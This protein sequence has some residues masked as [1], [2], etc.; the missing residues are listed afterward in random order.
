VTFQF[1]G[2]HSSLIVLRADL[3][4]GNDR[5][6][7]STFDIAHYEQ[8]SVV[9]VEFQMD[10]GDDTVVYEPTADLFGGSVYRM[11]IVTGAGS[12][13]VSGGVSSFV[14]DGDLTIDVDLGTG[15]DLLVWRPPPGVLPDGAVRISVAG[16]PGHDVVAFNHPTPATSSLAGLVELFVHGDDGNDEIVVNMSPPVSGSTVTGTVRVHADGGAGNDSVE[17]S[18]QNN[19][20]STGTLDFLVRGGLG[21][22]RLEL[23]V[24]GPAIYTPVGQALLDGGPGT[25]ECVVVGVAR[26]QNCEP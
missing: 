8:A 15:D 3:G 22:D 5:V 12:D 14:F 16:G 1:G 13:L 7:L 11:K 20:G 2:A 9:N 10:A 21:T 26:K 25:D 4:G 23:S 18:Q 19:P 17:V 6:T 24:T